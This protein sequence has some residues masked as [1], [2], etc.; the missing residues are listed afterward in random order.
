[1]TMQPGPTR[2][3]PHMSKLNLCYFS[4]QVCRQLAL[5]FMVAC[6]VLATS[7]GKEPADS[8]SAKPS[9]EAPVTPAALPVA[10]SAGEDK[11]EPERALRRSFRGAPTNS[12]LAQ[13]MLT[14]LEDYKGTAIED[15]A[16][17]LVARYT[18]RQGKSDY[19][20]AL[21][22]K[23]KDDPKAVL[24]DLTL[25]GVGG[26]G[27]L[28]GVAA[29]MCREYYKQ[30]P[31][32]SSEHAMLRIAALH[33]RAGRPRQAWK[34]LQELVAKYPTGDRVEGDLLYWQ[35]LHKFAAEGPNEG[36]TLPRLDFAALR[37]R[38]HLLALEAQAELCRAEERYRGQLLPTIVRLL[39]CYGA[40]LRDIPRSRYATEGLR[41]LEQEATGQRSGRDK[42]RVEQMLRSALAPEP[43]LSPHLAVPVVQVEYLDWRDYRRPS[44]SK[45]A[46]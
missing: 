27:E 45:G 14:L 5:A 20:I 2:M 46:P 31:I 7:Y 36:L 34:A 3:A 30:F 43:L 9:P 4:K 38:P 13:R 21:L 22:E 24:V 40:L 15:D 8:S 11:L 33:R 42:L 26:M 1:M 6:T 12:E 23:L 17:L 32:R 44:K 16:I 35:K 37:K 39:D 18:A 41:L 25:L 10:S 19:A 29:G 28:E